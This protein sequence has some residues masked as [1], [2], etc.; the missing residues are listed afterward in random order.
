[1]IRQKVSLQPGRLI[2]YFENPVLCTRPQ[3]KTLALLCFLYL[4]IV[5]S[6]A[7]Y[8]VV[9]E[10]GIREEELRLISVGIDGKRYKET[11]SK[12]KDSLALLLCAELVDTKGK[13]FDKRS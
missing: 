10:C 4:V 6:K 7:E 13:G 11:G 2:V 1:M 3:K 12:E 9:N 5:S 8:E